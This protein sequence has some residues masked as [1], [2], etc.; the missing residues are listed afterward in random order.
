MFETQKGCE[1]IESLQKKLTLIDTIED[2]QARQEGQKDRVFQNS[3][4]Y[5]GCSV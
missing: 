3:V 4:K 5:T 1:N 2:L